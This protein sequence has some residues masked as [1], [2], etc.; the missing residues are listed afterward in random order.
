MA[1]PD[2]SSLREVNAAL[3]RYDLALGTTD[4][5]WDLTKFR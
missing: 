2:R 5:H 3:M 1:Q 4:V